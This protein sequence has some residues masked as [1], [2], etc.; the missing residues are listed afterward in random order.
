MAG[1]AFH[2]EWLGEAEEEA[3][4][5]FGILISYAV[6]L[7]ILRPVSPKQPPNPGLALGP[8]GHLFLPAPGADWQPPLIPSLD[9]YL[10]SENSDTSSSVLA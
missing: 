9:T 1:R 2:G 6:F 3:E 4:K 7:W 8:S 10:P 5:E